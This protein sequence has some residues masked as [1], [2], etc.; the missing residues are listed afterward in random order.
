MS[1][2]AC[3]E[4]LQEYTLKNILWFLHMQHLATKKH[5]NIHRIWT[6]ATLNFIKLHPTY[7]SWS[8]DEFVCFFLAPV[9]FVSSHSYAFQNLKSRLQQQKTGSKLAWNSPEQWLHNPGCLGYYRE[10]I[11]LPSYVGIIY[12]SKPSLFGSQ[13]NNQDSME[14]KRDLFVAHLSFSEIQENPTG[15]QP[16]AVGSFLSISDRRRRCPG[17][18]VPSWKE[19]RDDLKVDGTDGKQLLLGGFSLRKA[20]YWY[21]DRILSIRCRF[22]NTKRRLFLAIFID[23][24][25]YLNIWFNILR[26]LW[27]GCRIEVPSHVIFPAKEAWMFGHQTEREKHQSLIGDIFGLTAVTHMLHVWDIYLHLA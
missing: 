18:A 22:F 5:I 27:K 16:S 10:A 26:S 3:E 12:S 25:T 4:Y 20:S 14:S 8:H 19:W 2:R 11:I 23:Q 7:L 9:A 13:W 1:L 15:P 24:T 21:T 17:D 6:K